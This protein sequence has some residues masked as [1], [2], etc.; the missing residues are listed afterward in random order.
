MN[1]FIPMKAIAVISAYLFLSSA[2]VLAQNDE[3]VFAAEKAA[4]SWLASVDAVEYANSWEDSASFFRAAITSDDWI[5]AIG[6]ARASF[7]SMTVRESGSAKY[8]TTLPG[9]PDGEWVVL[10]LNTTFENKAVAVETV[11]VM[12]D[13]DGEWRVAGYFIR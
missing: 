9:A 8:S 10:K 4:R 11:T 2:A 5:K 6:G 7:G 1:R 3:A 13:L 12:K